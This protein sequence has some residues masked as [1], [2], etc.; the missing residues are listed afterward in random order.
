MSAIGSDPSGANGSTP[1]GIAS[2]AVYLS[3]DS[4]PFTLFASVT[5]SSPSFLFA[6][7]VGNTYGFYSVATDVAGNVQPTPVAAQ[8]TVQIL[9]PMTVTSIGAV[10]PNPRNSRLVPTLTVTFSIPVNVSTFGASTL[11]L[12]DNDNPVA[13]NSSVSLSLVSGTTYDI[14]GLAGFTTAEGNYKPDRQCG[15][16]FPT[17]TAIPVA[18]PFDLVIDGH[19][20]ADE[21]GQHAAGPD[22]VHELQRLG[23]RQRPIGSNGSTPSG[24]TSITIYEST[25]SG[26]YSF[27]ATVSPSSPS[28]PLQ[29]PGWAHLQF[30]QR[31]NRQRRQRRIDTHRGRANRSDSP[32]VEYHLDRP[33]L[34]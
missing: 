3:T 7:Q 27:F 28:A 25:D 4:G 14:N 34:A 23:D 13:I 29:R 33:G 20:R 11:A 12:F 9:S 21:H 32:A 10:M 2:L 22:H 19:N 17:C 5:P 30:L 26:P 31:G 8:Q 24:V 6:G 15:R 1:S 18:A 16:H